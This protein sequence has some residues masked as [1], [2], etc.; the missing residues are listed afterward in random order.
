MSNPV[1]HCEILTSDV[2]ALHRFYAA[3]F[4]WQTQDVVD[5]SYH[6]MATSGADKGIHIGVGPAPAGSDGHLTFY[7]EVDDPAAVLAQIEQ[8]GG[9]T[10]QPP[11]RVSG[12]PLLAM[13]ADPQGHV[14][15]LVQ[16]HERG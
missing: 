16:R 8:L 6:I 13:F 1:T 14:V 2:G 15:G 9:R 4:G 10:V 3:A 7:V 11:M 5:G 12:G